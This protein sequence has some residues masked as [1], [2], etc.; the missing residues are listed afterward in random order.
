MKMSDILRHIAS[1]LD[2]KEAGDNGGKPENSMPH[3]ELHKVGKDWHKGD[4]K[5]DET[6]GTTMIPPLQQKLE[7]LKKASGEENAFDD[8]PSNGPMDELDAIKKIAGLA[9]IADGEQGEMG[10]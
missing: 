2:D 8:E 3:A 10:E 5:E 1:E 7:I 6:D 4:G 9:V